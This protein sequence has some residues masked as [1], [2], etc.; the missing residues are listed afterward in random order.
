MLNLSGV[1]FILVDP[2]AQTPLAKWFSPEID[3]VSWRRSEGAVV[4]ENRSALPRAFFIPSSGAYPTPARCID[5]LRVP[6]FDPRHDL[7]LDDVSAPAS[8]ATGDAQSR[9]SI[10]D[11]AP[12]RV[13]L[14]IEASTAGFV[15]LTDAFYPG[16][17]ASL[18]QRDAPVLRADCFFRAVPTPA[19]THTV[20]FRYAPW[21]F[22]LGTAVSALG[23][24]VL[25]TFIMTGRR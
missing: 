18:D 3:L 14:E 22:A 17:T 2:H 24:G 8:A 25:L 10:L 16:W 7:L 19:G 11:Y 1:R 23:L 4:Y 13:R 15:I 21:S 12:S 6:Q 20:E 9:V 5:A